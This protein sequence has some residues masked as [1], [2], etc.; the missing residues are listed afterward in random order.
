MSST[1]TSPRLQ[2]VL[3]VKDPA[4]TD[5]SEQRVHEILSAQPREYLQFIH[6]RLMGLARDRGGIV[7]LPSKQIFRDSF[8]PGDFRVMTCVLR[9]SDATWKVVKII[10]TNY[11][12]N[13]LPDQISVGQVFLLHGSDN[14]ITHR[15][16]GCLLSSAR[17]GACMTL[18]ARRFA[19]PVHRI[20]I[21]GAGRVGYYAALFASHLWDD[22][23]IVIADSDER[24]AELLAG[25]C[26]E[27]APWGNFEP[28]ASSAAGDT[29]LLFLATTSRV[30]VI[31]KAETR[32]RVVVSAGADAEDQRE[33]GDSFASNGEVWV[34]TFDSASVG[35]L[36]S[37]KDRGLSL[38]RPRHVLD[39]F[40]SEVHEVGA[41]GLCISTGSAL[42][43][44]LTVQYLVDRLPPV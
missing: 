24:K 3:R 15:F 6:D 9:H 40:S 30:P 31:E 20:G 22:A 21:I 29:D 37:W 1:G 27:V 14:H 19:G 41:I 8:I 33:L 2:Q 5:V 7:D 32:A 39:L 43:D 35:D 34:D 26:R 42:F 44:N 13:V 12:G 38:L 28:A 25:S 11:A 23:L 10:G 18:M 16:S 4:P 36:K 17:T